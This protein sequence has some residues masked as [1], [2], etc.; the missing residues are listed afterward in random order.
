M[1]ALAVN[2]EDELP[3]G[4]IELLDVVESSHGANRCGLDGH[5]KSR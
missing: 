3:K 1:T 5:S 2:V 4:V